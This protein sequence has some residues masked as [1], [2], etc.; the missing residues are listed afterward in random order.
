MAMMITDGCGVVCWANT[1]CGPLTGYAVDELVDRNAGMLES[2]DST[3]RLHNVLHHVFAA[4]EPWRG[5][6]GGRHKGGESFEIELTI[7]PV[8]D[9]SDAVS[10]ALWTLGGITGRKRAKEELWESREVL[11]AVLN[12]IPVRV[13]WKDRSLVY[14]GCNTPFARDAGF[15]KPEDLIGKDDGELSWREQA[16]FYRADDRA[17][18]ESGVARLLFEESQTTPQ[19]ER[20]H[21]LTSKVP[22]RDADGAIVGVLGTYYE[23]T[24]RKRAEE[25][26]RISE[27]RYRSILCASPDNITIA[28]PEGRI[29]MVS[30]VAL[31]MFGGEREEEWLGRSVVD[32]VVPE[33]RDRARANFALRFFGNATGPNE[34]RGLRFDG[35]TFDLEANSEFIRDSAGQITSMVFVIRDLTERKLLEAKFHQAQKMESIGR[36]AGGVA[37]DFNNLLT[38]INGYSQLLLEDGRLDETD[39]RSLTE[40]LK[41]GD[42]AARL[43]AQLLAY[44]RKQVL[45]VRPLNLN[46]VVREMRSMLQRL[47]GEDVEV[48]VALN[49]CAGMV[50]ADPQQLDQVIMNLAVNAKDAM[51]EGGKLTIETANVELDENYVETHLGAPLGPCVMLALSD[52]GVGMDKQTQRKIFEPF[53]TTKGVGKGTGLG[54]SMVQGIVAQSGGFIDVYSE[55]GYGTTFKIYL[56]ALTDAAADIGPVA[57]TPVV[58]GHETVLVVEDQHGVLQ[59][60][61]AALT[62]YGYRVLKADNI[63]EALQVFEQERGCIDLVLTDVI[64]PNGSGRELADELEKGRPG[65]KVLFMSGYTDDAIARHGVLEEGEEFIQKPFSPQQLA[66]KVRMVLG[67]Q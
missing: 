46:N 56:P 15:E 3:P 58:R 65:I 39:R 67:E 11:Q 6:W 33:D 16:E 20:I 31:K 66:T 52:T 27:E 23:I 26:L 43:T 21:L 1:P 22:L 42:R 44:S 9:S 60:A 7:T 62:A 45:Q 51:P 4:G 19:G 37:H 35:S 30:P 32:F 53:F 64:M 55:R 61:V 18:I 54:L 24:D 40:I 17:V 41:A 36:L 25:A 34:Y 63:G 10:H 28:D 59:Y 47:L 48:C 2:K 14:L 5:E 12:S 8:R 49:A 57:A 38:V 13:F 29:L 50:Q